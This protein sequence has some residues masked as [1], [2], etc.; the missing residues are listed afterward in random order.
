MQAFRIALLC[1]LLGLAH[2]TLADARQY[3]QT[4]FSP[5]PEATALIV[6]TIRGAREGI[7]VA[8]YSFTS[9]PVAD[10]LAAAYDKGVDVRV[11]A[12]KSQAKDKRSVVGRLATH[13]IAVRI[14]RKYAIMHNKFLVVDG[15]IVQTG[16]FNYTKSAERRNAENVMVIRN[17]PHLAGKYLQN[18]QKLWDEGDEYHAGATE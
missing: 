17:N 6:R 14:N 2:P 10:A 9:Q 16:S 3:T 1:V 7:R 13:G 12:D 5:S 18:W 4:A 11:V 8:A 15:R